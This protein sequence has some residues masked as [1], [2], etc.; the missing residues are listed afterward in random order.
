MRPA[1]VKVMLIGAA[2][3]AVLS[4]LEKLT[5]RGWFDGL[6]SIGLVLYLASQVVER[7]R[8]T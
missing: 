7:D 3:F 8:A 5:Y 6:V 2:M 1:I 4:L